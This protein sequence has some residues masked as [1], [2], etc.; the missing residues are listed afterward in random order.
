MAKLVSASGGVVMSSLDVY[1]PGLP[2]MQTLRHSL[3]Y[4]C[5]MPDRPLSQAADTWHAGVRLVSANLPCRSVRCL[6]ENWVPAQPLAP[7][8]Q[9][10]GSIERE[11]KVFA[12]ADK[13]FPALVPQRAGEVPRGRVSDM[14]D[15]AELGGSRL[16]HA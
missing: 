11:D 16:M 2:C 8:V 3:A 9:L 1:A 7:N 6:A 5:Y 12:F 14:E 13:V 15:V 4:L 10:W